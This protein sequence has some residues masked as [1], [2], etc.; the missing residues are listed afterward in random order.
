M[1]ENEKS[2]NSEEREKEVIT[3]KNTI[4][5]LENDL[6]TSQMKLK[7]SKR[8]F[9]S[10]FELTNDAIFLIDLDGNYLSANQ[11]AA[12]LLGF[13]L[14]KITEI[15][16]YDSIVPE[17]HPNAYNKL[18][19]VKGGGVLPIYERTFRKRNGV[20][21]TAEVNLSIVRDDE[22]NDLY[23]QSIVRDISERKNFEFALKRDRTV[24]RDLAL[25]VLET[26]DM[27]EFSKFALQYIIENFDLEFGTI[28]IFDEKEAL[29]KPIAVYGLT[30]S[31]EENII[32]LSLKDKEYI[33]SYILT[34]K[35]PI[36]E[37]DTSKARKLQNFRERLALYDIKSLIAWPLIDSENK[38]V[39]VIQLSSSKV[40]DFT[41]EDKI[42]FESISQLLAIGLE[43][44]LI[45]LELSKVFDEQQQLFEI[46]NL[47]P[48]IVFLW[49]NEKDWPVDFVS[50]NISEFG[51]SVEEFLDG[52]VNYRGLI[53]EEDVRKEGL[54]HELYQHK[55]SQ[56]KFPLEYRIKNKNGD[57]R[58]IM[59]YSTPRTNNDGTITHYY[60]IIFDITNRKMNEYSLEKERKALNIIAQ[61][62][63]KTDVINEFCESIITELTTTLEFEVGTIR[64][65][66]PEDNSLHL[67]A[68][69]HRTGLFAN[70][71]TIL[72][73]ENEETITTLVAR[74]KDPIFS[75]TML[76]PRLKKPM[77]TRLLELGIKAHITYPLL[78][79]KQQLLGTIQLVSTKSLNLQE[80]DKI[81]FESIYKLLANAIERMLAQNELKASEEQFRTTVDTMTDG[82]SIIKNR[83]IIYVNDRACEIYGY[84]K[85]EYLK[86]NASA[87]IAPED[88]ERYQHNKQEIIKNCSTYVE[89]EYW[90]IQKNGNRRC[91]KN[92][93]QIFYDENNKPHT[94]YILT[95]D[96]TERKIAEENI[97]KL[98]EELELRVERRTAQLKQANKELEAFSY[99]VSHDLRTPLRSIYGF[100]QALL[101]DYHKEIDSTG[102]D[103]LNRIK[104][105]SNRMGI[106]IDDLIDLSQINR[107]TI[108]LKKFNLSKLSH[109]IIKEFK[110]NYPERNVKVNIQDNLLVNAD[111]TL[112]RVVMENLI[113]NAWKF[114]NKK[115]E[116]II[117]IGST[118]RDKEK[119]YYVKDDGAGFNIKY[120]DKLFTVFQ[121][122]HSIA[123]F[124]GTGIGLAIVQKVISKHHGR[125]WAESEINEGATFYFTLHTETQ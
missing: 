45:E 110:E 31:M 84:P 65:L 99:S 13:D 7:E 106:L 8:N 40:K 61:E 111:Q 15:S 73:L 77:I 52:S 39:G 112:L 11:R 42:L 58:W 56:Y 67:V 95:S 51:Y 98:N 80:S 94:Q 92:R 103:Y 32:A 125:I 83:K 89:E 108:K 100:S 55:D 54:S 33:A 81:F 114:T 60:G 121:R 18:L 124:D 12:D 79:S 105:A 37:P 30:K 38:V 59:E 75:T 70:M 34:S 47:S 23:I 1:T 97:K 25:K 71:P 85:E 16:A 44:Y 123:E 116:A 26:K 14:S 82:I 62:A 9:D 93:H 72:P 41:A 96:I 86:L 43:K 46:I 117:E 20:V 69:H 76:S 107:K 78:D 4:N 74:T 115:E 49:R 66:N 29:L 50:D 101:E 48:A 102:Q 35:K 21:F 113:G 122:L 90:I 27:I 88:K 57:L 53:H 22:G 19:E 68:Q 10:L 109:E 17:E 120:A 24:F 36:F 2:N 87:F 63:V 91:V 28:R 104:N 6:K 118:F 5:K 64:L 119:I 3:L